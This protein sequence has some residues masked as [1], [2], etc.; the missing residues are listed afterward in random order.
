MYIYNLKTHTLHI[1]GFCSQTFAG[2][3]LGDDHKRFSTED[4]A[5]AF[6]GRGVGMCK[7]CQRKREEVIFNC[8]RKGRTIK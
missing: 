4:E 8:V 7:N 3:H 5:L 1:E 6:D 2:M